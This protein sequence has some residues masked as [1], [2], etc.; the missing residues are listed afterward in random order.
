[1]ISAVAADFMKGLL[2]KNYEKR[3]G[4]NGAEEIKKH[5]FF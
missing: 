3:L 5:K 4:Y 2:E 1:M